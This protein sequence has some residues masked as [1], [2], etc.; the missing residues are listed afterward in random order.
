M[1]FLFRVLLLILWKKICDKGLVHISTV[2]IIEFSF[3]G[4][5]KEFY[6]AFER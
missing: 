2:T 1:I 5:Y 6:F 3:D 4:G